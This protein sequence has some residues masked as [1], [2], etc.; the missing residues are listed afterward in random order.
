MSKRKMYRPLPDE[1]KISEMSSIEGYGLFT[2]N[3]M[4][5]GTELGITHIK[6]E[7]GNFHSNYIRTPLGGFVNHQENNPNC[8][9]Y[10]CGEYVKMKTKADIQAGEECNFE[11]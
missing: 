11:L 8:S 10:L 7:S 9:L 2:L 1:D 5:E 6:D 4:D 3:Y